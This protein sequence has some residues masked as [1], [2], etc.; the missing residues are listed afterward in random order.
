MYAHRPCRFQEAT[1][2]PGDS[3]HACFASDHVTES[4][5]SHVSMLTNRAQRKVDRSCTAPSKNWARYLGIF[6]GW[7]FSSFKGHDSLGLHLLFYTSQLDNKLQQHADVI[8]ASFTFPR[9][10]TPFC[11]F[12]L[13]RLCTDLS[14]PNTL[15]EI[16]L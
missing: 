5:H 10:I 4:K 3:K 8:S 2:T 9:T 12:E 7:G 1:Q 11:L 6:T 13:L 15:L 14:L 16:Q